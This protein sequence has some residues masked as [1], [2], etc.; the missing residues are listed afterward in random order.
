MNRG[1][2]R[3]YGAGLARATGALALGALLVSGAPL[4]SAISRVDQELAARLRGH[5]EIL[6]SDDFDG[7]E[8][9]TDGE[10]KTL[11]YLGKQ[12]FD[13][14]L[15][16][17]TNDPGH[18]WFAPVTLVA[19]EPDSS[20]ARFLRKGARTTVSP[21]GVLVLTSGKRSLVRNVPMLF[22]GK[23]R[24]RDFTRTE[25]AGRV[26]VVLDGD[27]PDGERQ[28]DLLAL[29]ASAVLTVLDGDRSLDQVAA[30]RKRT[31]YALSDDALGGDLEAFITRE[32]MASLL[33]GT[34][35]SLDGLEE[36]AAKADFVP[37]TLDITASLEATTRETTIRTHNLIGKLPGKRPESGAVLF[38]AHWDH[39]G[40]CGEAPAEDVICN[41]AI[42]N[43]SG[44]AA[45]TEVARRLAR[46]QQLDRDIYFL[47][48]TG[49]ELGL[50]GAHAFAENPPLPPGQIVAAFN[51]DSIAIAPRGTPF[52]I[53]GRGMTALDGEIAKVAKAE[54]FKLRA[55]DDANE[56]VRRQD[57]WALIQHDI[58]AVMV[59]TTY[60]DMDRMRTFFEG[61]YHRPSDDLAHMA[62]P[63]E[64]GGAVDD[65]KMLTALGRWFGDLRRVPANPVE[66]AVPAPERKRK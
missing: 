36:A 33:K 47:A 25:L 15:V 30:R 31:G 55:N 42:D 3:R 64:L 56:Y 49:E 32:A 2:D 8:P 37:V 16:S 13:I 41:G 23:A 52:A 1:N 4:L 62:R 12:W 29:G 5:I 53:V 38:L 51:I 61:D 58:P 6:A 59:T 48:T 20:A 50:L 18:E 45:L 57:G 11:R 66:P 17:G 24:G 27:T 44:V 65:V 35:R 26:A 40:E 34:S 46:G 63:L 54:R 43:A 10:A 14:G 19:R 9:G 60:G 39:F 21:P 7:R 28:N 22:L